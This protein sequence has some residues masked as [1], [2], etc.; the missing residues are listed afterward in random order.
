[1]RAE[2]YQTG[3]LFGGNSMHMQSVYGGM[4]GMPGMQAMQAMQGMQGMD[5]MT[6]AMMGYGMPVDGSM[7]GMPA[8]TSAGEACQF[9]ARSGWCKFGDE[10]R[11]EHAGAT[12]M[13]TD[14]GSFNMSPAGMGK[15]KG[16]G[17]GGGMP[18]EKSGEACGFFLKSG[19]CKFGG[20]CR[21]EHIAGPDTP[22]GVIPDMA[23][24]SGMPGQ[25][26]GEPCGFFRTKGWCK[27]G[28]Q[29]KHEHIA[30]P[31][32]PVGVIPGM[33]M[34]G[35]MPGQKSGEPCGFFLKSGWCGYGDQCKHEHIAGPDT[36][37][38]V[39]PGMAMMGGMPGQKSGEPCGF[40]RTKGWC[41][42]GAQCKHEHIAGPETPVGVI[43]DMAM[44]GGMP[45]QKS[46]EPC[47]FFRTKGW[48]KWGDQCKHEHIAGPSTP[49][50][51]IPAMSMPAA[52]PSGEA[53]KF[54]GRLLG[55][56]VQFLSQ[57]N[58]F[59]PMAYGNQREPCG[60]FMRTGT[61]K[62]GDQC[63]H[64]H[65]G[66]SGMPTD[67]GSFNMS[68]AG[69]GMGK[70]KGKGGGVPGERSGE[71]CGF[72]LKAG[73]CKFG[74]ECR[75]E[76]IA[77]PDT[78]VG[79]I[80]DMGGMGGQRSGEHCGFFRTKG[81]CKWGDQCKHQ[82]VADAD[83]PIGVIPPMSMSAPDMGGMV[84]GQSGEACGFFLT[85]GWCKW[86]EQCKH[87]HMVGPETPM[88]G[89]DMGG[90]QQQIQPQQYGGQQQQAFMG[91]MPQ[92]S[93]GQSGEPCGFFMTKGWCKWGDQCKHVHVAG[94]GTQQIQPQQ[95]G[96][97]LA[98]L[99]LTFFFFLFS[100]LL[101]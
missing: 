36:P 60:F 68:P 82:H 78:P 28:D 9:F 21:H 97:N 77:G 89:M 76:H 32:T 87:V 74:Q 92:M 91:G 51:V 46:G 35:G 69:M 50:G 94:P 7:G 26:S 56:G 47:G 86:G 101:S 99:R 100:Y 43:P 40:F 80:P 22:V 53:C 75:H 67:G 2:P 65:A 3:M 25:R 96:G 45:G 93:G 85:K 17:K 20:E 62:W 5:A 33:A 81:W 4:P 23:M 49:V 83:T 15:G 55:I 79:V 11:Y 57:L 59:V 13:P 30:G 14:G 18:G 98:L 6:L 12:G 90:M 95:Y 52:G 63:K 48:C 16:K 41:G 38:G 1:M 72:F 39:I 70:G 66:A 64:E 58:A 27:W 42:Y 84:G 61:C 71:A 44:M 24:M 29:C 8:Q 19:W 31:E 88:G 37:V 10:C 73:W 54:F 34:M